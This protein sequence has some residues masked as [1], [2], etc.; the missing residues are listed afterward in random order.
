MEE[1]EINTEEYET[2]EATENPTG[3][4]Y[5]PSIDRLRIIL[6]FF[7]CIS[8]FGF[9]TAV[10]NF[11]QTICGFVPIA[12]FIISGYLVLRQDENRT[13]RIKRAIK[14]TAI[15]FFVLLIVYFLV[16]RF[17]YQH[18]DISI[19]S[20]MVSKRFW[21]NFIFMN[22]WQ[23]KI[24]S[25]IWY[26]QALLYAY[27]II[28]FLDKWKLLRFDLLIA[29]A[30]IL[31]T[32][33]TGELSGVL[34]WNIAG[35]NYIPGNFFTRALPYILMGGFISRKMNTP[36]TK[37]S[38]LCY[39][40]IVIGVILVVA[41]IV[42]LGLLGVPGYYGH[43]I[44]MPIMAISICVLAFKK[45]DTSGFEE[46]LNMSRWH[47]N[48]IYYFCPLASALVAFVLTRFDNEFLFG[49]IGYIG[50]LTFIICFCLALII[51]FISNAISS[52]INDAKEMRET[53]D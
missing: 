19:W 29:V 22:V 52:S 45:D 49:T 4:S 8:L 5:R 41:E 53:D 36:N 28:Y 15:V 37:K 39:F 26:V 30:L 47:I 46:R 11:V 31:L 6:M 17:Y 18:L 10:G 34:K 2:E 38:A 12:F 3:L 33:L 13:A 1:K 9:P 51:T 21:F 20:L 16:N 27:I 43:L 50:I 40:G 24:G 48:C 7:M 44:G 35:Y 14:R 25:S 32:V 23:F 42:V